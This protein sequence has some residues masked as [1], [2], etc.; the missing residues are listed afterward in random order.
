MDTTLVATLTARNQVFWPL[1]ATS[2][3]AILL[4]AHPMGGI[5]DWTIGKKPTSVFRVVLPLLTTTPPRAL[6]A[7]HRRVVVAIAS[8]TLE[9]G[10]APH[11]ARAKGARVC[12]VSRTPGAGHARP[13][14]VAAMPFTA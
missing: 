13:D 1:H 4:A 10:H 2:T 3:P 8:P 7:P 9:E 14:A 11:D 12:S 5:P 6:P